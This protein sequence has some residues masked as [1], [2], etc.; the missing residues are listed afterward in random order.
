MKRVLFILTIL[1]CVSF[2]RKDTALL[3]PDSYARVYKTE[4]YF[5][6]WFFYATVKQD[7]LVCVSSEDVA[8]TIAVKEFYIDTTGL[9]TIRNIENRG[10]TLYFSYYCATT[11]AASE[12]GKI[13]ILCGSGAPGSHKYYKTTFNHLPYWIE[14]PASFKEFKN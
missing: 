2:A 3:T 11:D 1:L 12:V 9:S 4:R 6:H 7:T 13:K 5:E 8:A 14:N 10:D